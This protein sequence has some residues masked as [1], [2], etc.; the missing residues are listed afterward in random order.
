VVVVPTCAGAASDALLQE[1]STWN[2]RPDVGLHLS[3]DKSDLAAQLSACR[4][5]IGVGRV[6]TPHALGSSNG[7]FAASAPKGANANAEPSLGYAPAP[8]PDPI[9]L[10]AAVTAA[11][12][13]FGEEEEEEE[14]GAPEPE[15]CRPTRL[16]MPTL[17]PVSKVVTERLVREPAQLSASALEASTV[18]TDVAPARKQGTWPVL[19]NVDICQPLPGVVNDCLAHVQACC[20]GPTPQAR[21]L[22]TEDTE[23]SS[24]AELFEVLIRVATEELEFEVDGSGL[25]ATPVPGPFGLYCPVSAHEE[26][27]LRRGEAPCAVFFG[28]AIFVCAGQERR[29]RFLRNPAV[30]TRAWQVP[31][32]ICVLGDDAARVAE[33]SQ[34]FANGL[35]AKPEDKPLPI[36]SVRQLLTEG[37]PSET[38]ARPPKAGEQPAE[39]AADEETAEAAGEENVAGDAEA[40][41]V[42]PPSG[43]TEHGED[44]EEEEEEGDDNQVP[45][46][47]RLLRRAGPAW[48]MTC[49]EADL[50]EV[51]NVLGLDMA[52]RAVAAIVP[53]APAASNADEANGDQD[54]GEGAGQ[55]KA[56]A[57]GSAKARGMPQI[58]A[59]DVDEPDE[60]LSETDKARS[61][62]AAAAVASAEAEERL[63]HLQ[64]QFF[65]LL[66]ALR[67]K[68][69]AICPLP[70]TRTSEGETDSELELVRRAM[71]CTLLVPPKEAEHE[72]DHAEDDM[73]KSYGETARW[74]VEEEKGGR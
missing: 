15:R 24:D 20:A 23:F 17:A 63:A 42:S 26:N 74:V 13:P 48:I 33:V 6:L 73:A 51:E 34:N 10:A 71:Q 44:D 69:S 61:A 49:T 8:P 35:R 12:V 3:A 62:E 29:Q 53:R 46:L 36:F 50:S 19:V 67:D 7:L 16:F 58:V 72:V 41:D 31:A 57:P 4:Y 65:S 21:P 25:S 37:L 47:G 55:A 1:I 39:A 45:L 56:S 66:S 43:A 9:A 52:P 11:A 40:A 64:Q 2:L 18:E 30:Y 60:T 54:E 38:E 22:E 14:G 70:A 32:R 27:V 68:I 59:N 28:G 5:D